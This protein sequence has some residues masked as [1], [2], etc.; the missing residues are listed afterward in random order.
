MSG[1]PSMEQLTLEQLWKKIDAL[2][3][4]LD[5]LE[6]QLRQWG[7]KLGLKKASMEEVPE[8]HEGR[9]LPGK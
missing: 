9:L 2:E 3:R 4:R 1:L 5:K 6:D 7:F 8:E